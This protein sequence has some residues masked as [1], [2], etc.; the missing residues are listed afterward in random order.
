MQSTRDIQ[1]KIR[2]VRNIQQIC[3]AMKTVSSIKLRRA[4]ERILTARPYAEALR[5]MVTRLGG[6]ETS[7]PLLQARPAER[8][9]VIAISAD[10]G[11]A[12]S[13]NTNVIRDA[14]NLVKALG[15]VRTITLGRKVS[16]AFRRQGFTI[17]RAINPLGNSPEFRTIAPLADYIGA[18]YVQGTLDRVDLVYTVFGESVTTMQLL[19]ILP[20]EGEEVH[21]DFIYEPDPGAILEQILPRYLR[22]LLYTAVLSAVAAEHAA[23][24]T[25]MS[26]A[27]ENADDLIHKLTMDYNK[28]R[29][30]SITG[31]LGDIVGAAE[32]LR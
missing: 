11:L 18:Q 10:K 27:T 4:E 15:D 9:G 24:V 2:T 6:A 1:R 14:S 5:S 19:P 30:A 28:S 16:D 23:R 26:L 13:Y 3:R 32:A 22:T 20:P 7:H 8:F 29:Q 25:A 31:E 17:D 21:G 12:G